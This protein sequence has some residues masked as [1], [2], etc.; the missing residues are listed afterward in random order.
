MNILYRQDQNAELRV[1]ILKA[2][3][4]IKQSVMEIHRNHVLDKSPKGSAAE[5]LRKKNAELEEKLRRLEVD[6]E[7]LAL[8]LNIVKN[9]KGVTEQMHKMK[10]ELVY[11]QKLQ[12]LHGNAEKALKA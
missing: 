5:G 4:D 2:Q 9:S 7:K 3:S 10:K 6:K 11:A 12:A 1:G 8:E